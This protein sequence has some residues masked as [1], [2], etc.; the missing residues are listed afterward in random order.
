MV[1]C[2]QLSD[3]MAILLRVPEMR[4]DFGI[5]SRREGKQKAKAM[6]SLRNS[7]AH[8]QPITES[9]WEA[10]VLAARRLERILTRL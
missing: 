6:E 10:M 5:T 1:D 9:N 8:N 4:E 3:K 7:L 2:L